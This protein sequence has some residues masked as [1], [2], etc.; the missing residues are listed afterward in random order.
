MKKFGF[1]IF[2]IALIVGSIVAGFFDWGKT[3]AKLFNFELKI[4]KV[5]GNGNVQTQSRDIRGFKSVDVSGVFQVEIVAQKDF[6]VQ[7]E[8]D[9]NLLQYIRTEV[10]GDVLEIS[11]SK[12]I[13]SS[14][15]LKV[16]ISAPDIEKLDV[17][18]AAKVSVTDLKNVALLLDTSGA[19]KIN[20]AGE[21]DK[22]IIDVSGASSI[23]A[24]NLKTRA[25][26]VDAS[27]ASKISVFASESVRADASGAS[28]ITYTGGAADIVKKSSG[29]SSVSER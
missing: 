20:L 6:S 16:R 19:S 17:S 3:S 14:S 12:G 26:T 18:G 22:L 1:L 13:K 15:G 8:A 5:R 25:A 7:V 27:G 11:T 23:E 24:E 4:G 10:D 29:A 9:E 2:V 28:R 21:T